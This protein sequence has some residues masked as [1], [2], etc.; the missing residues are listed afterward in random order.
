MVLKRTLELA[1]DNSEDAYHNDEHSLSNDDCEPPAKRRMTA[2]P[3]TPLPRRLSFPTPRT[4]WTGTPYPA[5]PRDSPSN[6][7]GRKRPRTLVHSLP[8]PTS[9]S[10]H[11]PLR[12]QFVRPG[13]SPR[14]GGIY[15]I[16][17][18]PLSYTF[19]QL[20]CLIAFLFGGGH[21]D[22]REDR[23]LFEVKKKIVLYAQ[24]YKPGQIRS[25]Y[26]ATRL[27][28]ARDPCRYRPQVDEDALLDDEGTEEKSWNDVERVLEEDTD[29]GEGNDEDPSWTWEPEEEFTVGHA[30]SRGGDLS[31]GIVYHHN[32]TTAVHITLNTSPLPR[33]SGISNTPYVFSGRGRVRIFPHSIIPLPKPVF[34]VPVSKLLVPSFRPSAWS[35]SS[36]AE[37]HDE[38]A[39]GED[40]PEGG[41]V[42]SS[43]FLDNGND[44]ETFN[45]DDDQE[46][47]GEDETEDPN[48]VLN[49][50]KFNA[51]NAFATYLR[52]VHQHKGRYHYPR[53]DSDS[54]GEEEP[55]LTGQ[56]SETGSTPGLVHSGSSSAPSS[57]LASSSSL[58]IASSPFIASSSRSG[59]NSDDPY[60]TSL[61][62]LSALSA[63]ASFTPAPAHAL[64]QRRR[65]E[66][67]QK[68]MEKYKRR[69]WMCSG[70]DDDE[71][72]VDQLCEDGK[73][74]KKDERKDIAS[75]RRKDGKKRN[76]TDPAKLPPLW[77]K[78]VLKPGEVWDPFGDELEV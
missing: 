65:L 61:S 49:T 4:P 11:L 52:F 27:S 17:Q 51:P 36:A 45:S 32:E 23:H 72:E 77:V 75:W 60:A 2:L 47:I 31:R 40:D 39:E 53:S 28:S 50:E 21:G 1:G 58:G 63:S 20:R 5:R 68:R 29:E 34:S 12:F 14:M 18:V 59:L 19:V 10:K 37:E 44:E 13:V 6:P 76:V 48:A 30:W 9:F 15:R 78:P 57:P 24:T 67:V 64:W 74:D 43:G 71:E 26:T 3:Q 38:D 54:S 66:R 33:R 25:G 46:E 16:V 70:N 22:E 35:T 73:K 62:T 55:P 42:T 7:V 56:S 41:D 8:P 69:Q